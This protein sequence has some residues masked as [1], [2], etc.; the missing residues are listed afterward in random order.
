[1]NLENTNSKKSKI[2]IVHFGLLSAVR[3][4]RQTAE[5]TALFPRFGLRQANTRTTQS[6]S[7]T[8]HLETSEQWESELIQHFNK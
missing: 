6:F 7:A 8:K 1:M 5:P 3:A 4:S 2:N